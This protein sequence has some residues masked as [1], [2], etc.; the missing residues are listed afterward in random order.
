MHE[1]CVYSANWIENESHG[2]IFSDSVTI[3]FSNFQYGHNHVIKVAPAFSYVA[4]L[5]FNLTAS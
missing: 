5:L 3:P 2:E 4:P 1:F